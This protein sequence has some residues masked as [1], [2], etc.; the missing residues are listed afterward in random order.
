MLW[1]DEFPLPCCIFL[2]LKSNLRNKKCNH[3]T[4]IK[5]ILRNIIFCKILRCQPMSRNSRKGFLCGVTFFCA[6]QYVLLT[7]KWEM[8]M[9]EMR[10]NNKNRISNSNIDNN[11]NRKWSLFLHRKWSGRNY[12]PIHFAYYNCY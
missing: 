9:S 12:I 11:N 5:K 4:C 8:E 1:F 7:R 2:K 6:K 3:K 10:E